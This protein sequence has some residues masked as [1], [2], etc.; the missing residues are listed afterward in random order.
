MRQT[1]QF[2][3][4]WTW[5]LSWFIVCSVASSGSSLACAAIQGEPEAV[6]DE[7]KLI[8]QLDQLQ[9]QL[10][11]ADLEE[12]KTAEKEII[13]LGPWVLDYL[14][15]NPNASSD[16]QVRIARIRADLEKKEIVKFTQASKVTLSGTY[17]VEAA[18]AVI[19]K[20]TGNKISLDRVPDEILQSELKLEFDG[21]EFWKA[22]YDLIDRSGLA[23]DPYA[24]ESGTLTLTARRSGTGENQL[25]SDQ[26][27]VRIPRFGVGLF[28]CSIPRILS[29]RDFAKPAA[30][31]NQLTLLVRWEPR[32]NPISIDMPYESVIA[33]DDDGN[34]L[35]LTRMEGVFHGATSAESQELEI[36][37]PL[38]LTERKIKRIKS[39]EAELI[40]VLPG[41]QETFRFR[42]IGNL[43]AGVE[44]R[45]GGATVSFDGIIKN[46]DLFGVNLTL[47]FD[48]SF[49]A[50]ESY[51]GW[52]YDNPMHLE[53]EDGTTIEPVTIE[54]VRQSNE[55]VSIRYYFLEDPK[56]C[57]IVYKSVGAIVKHN[58]LLKITDIDFP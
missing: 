9:Q 37:I 27:A 57:N 10:E 40:A 42:K 21:T 34:E 6:Q 3:S 31:M 16:A 4:N 29:T 19:S 12:R 36:F 32:L 49:N 43:E 22:V 1:Q 15:P 20:Q 5:V 30:S 41:R 35:P 33:V 8:E 23:I 58:V 11:S 17:S 7:M 14:E 38:K 56:D 13:K 46:E 51:R 44:Q 55:M 24:G 18:C 25:A 50:L 54:G 2:L 53:K 45:K 47:R 39:L 26:P 48:E 28:D 52:A